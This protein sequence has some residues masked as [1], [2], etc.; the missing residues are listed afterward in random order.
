MILKL[1]TRVYPSGAR[2]YRLLDAIESFEI[3]EHYQ[4]G[5]SRGLIP[6]IAGYLEEPIP[7]DA[8]SWDGAFAAADTRTLCSSDPGRAVNGKAWYAWVK[9][10]VNGD[11][12]ESTV[13]FCEGYL[14]NDAG[15]TLQVFH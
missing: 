4:W 12:D 7:D 10:R 13:L 11:L 15:D 9:R 1:T 5:E 3:L 14:L 8:I 6:T 2:N